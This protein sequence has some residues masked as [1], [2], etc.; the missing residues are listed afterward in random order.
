MTKIGAVFSEPLKLI[1][2]FHFNNAVNQRSAD[3][4]TSPFPVGDSLSHCCLRRF[5]KRTAC[6]TLRRA[7]R[8]TLMDRKVLI[9]ILTLNPERLRKIKMEPIQLQLSFPGQQ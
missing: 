9:D 8:E 3:R 7:I 6:V 1:P 4:Y 2:R 5:L